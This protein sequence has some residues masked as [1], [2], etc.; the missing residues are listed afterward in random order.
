M[1]G[2]L[3]PGRG[4]SAPA[5]ARAPSRSSAVATGLDVLVSD[6]FQPLR[7][8]RIGLITNQTGIDRER[9]STI[10]LL[11]A[12]P[13]VKLTALFSPEHGIRGALDEKVPD[14]R[15]DKTGLP[16]YSLYGA[17]RA[18]KPAQLADCDALVFDIQDIG[19]RFYTYI[20]TLGECLTVAGQAKKKFFVLDRPNP[21]GGQRV[22]GPVL[23]AARSFT[24][25]HEVPIRHGMTVGELARM[26]NA[27]RAL[28]VD[29]EVVPCVGWERDQW[30]DGTGLPWVNPSP[31]MRTLSAA[32]LY[33][34]IGLLEFCQLSVGRGTDRPFEIL[35]AP[36]I[37]DRALAQTLNAALLD[38]VRF[39]PVR[40]TPLTSTFA[41]QE[42]GGVQI[43]LTDRDVLNAVDLGVVIAS[44]LH[45]LYP[46]H[47]QLEKMD[48]LLADPA[49]L[50]AI[51]E[52]RPLHS[53][54]AAWAP[55]RERFR[56]R[57][58]AFLLYR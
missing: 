58:A 25:W 9:R 57:R 31:N 29:L 52:G 36:Y 3:E 56:E 4:V 8:L 42:C 28:G 16:I 51:R 33:P 39:V 19:C 30:F 1:P 34:G 2:A 41:G 22:E 49:T 18:P 11:H 43:V 46:R 5:R 44:T 35:G 32:T 37:D 54:R 21:I 20:S 7:G 27:E 13:G 40:F 12:A 17:T 6:E 15:D 38:G 14:G 26:F 23:A 50:A 55:E 47:L 53:I 45:R 10:D 24:G 48:R